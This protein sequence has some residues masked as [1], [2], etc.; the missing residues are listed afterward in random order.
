MIT[1]EDVEKKNP[2]WRKATGRAGAETLQADEE[3]GRDR[4]QAKK[5]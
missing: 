5:D 2:W 1:R 4:Q 3:E